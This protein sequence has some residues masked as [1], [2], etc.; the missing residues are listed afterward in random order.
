MDSP[1]AEGFYAADTSVWPGS[2]ENGVDVY[3][4]SAGGYTAKLA[5]E[6]IVKELQFTYICAI[7][8]EGKRG[9]SHIINVSMVP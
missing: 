6:T 9:S 4:M 3:E 7:S 2:G 8:F 1:S 5:E